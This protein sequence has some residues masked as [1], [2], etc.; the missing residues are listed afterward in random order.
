M[1]MGYGRFYPYYYWLLYNLF[2]LSFNQRINTKVKKLQTYHY[3]FNILI[4]IN[5]N[6]L[7]TSLDL[8][9]IFTI[10]I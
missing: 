9:N 2:R 1:F 8:P 10:Y 5:N 3:F 6:I 7:F 4:N